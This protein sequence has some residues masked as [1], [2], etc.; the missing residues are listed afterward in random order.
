MR[1]TR[2]KTYRTFSVIALGLALGVQ[3]GIANRNDAVPLVGAQEVTAAVQVYDEVLPVCSPDGRWL[4]FE[5]SDMN[6]PNYPHV[7]IMPL[8]E[9]SHSWHPLLNVGSGSHLF[10]GDFSWSPDSQ[11]LALVTDYP[12]GRKSFW[13]DT[14]IQIAKVNIY[15]NEVVRL[16]DFPLG[17][18]F[19][20]TTAWLRSGLIVFA[21]P[22]ENIYGVPEKGGT[23]RKLIDVPAANCGGGTNTLTVSPDEQRIAF[24]MDEDGQGQIT[25]CNAVWIGEPSTS[26]LLRVR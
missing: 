7:G 22:D 15:T 5:Y 6:D 19:G 9:G 17:T 14:D 20:P 18:H 23:P 8:D 1:G 25:E 16:T 2:E 11:W 10:A 4:A 24:A 3:L 26:K 12:K 21:G 13:S